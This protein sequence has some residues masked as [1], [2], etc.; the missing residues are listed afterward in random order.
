MSPSP[1]QNGQIIHSS[2]AHLGLASDMP[3]YSSSSHSGYSTNQQV[4]TMDSQSSSSSAAPVQ[5]HHHHHHLHAPLSARLGSDSHNMN[6]NQNHAHSNHGH[7]HS[8]RES[9]HPTENRIMVAVRSRPLT[10]KERML[11]TSQRARY[12]MPVIL[13]IQD[14][15][16]FLLDPDS[17]VAFDGAERA[18]KERVYTFDKVFDEYSSNDDVY[19]QT[20]KPLIDGVL[21]GYNATCFAYGMTGAGKTY[22]MMGRMD[23]SVKG[24]YALCMDDIFQRIRTDTDREYRVRVSFLEI[25][26]EKI[27][28]LLNP[29]GP[30]YLDLHE[31]PSKGMVVQ[32]LSEFEV[33]NVEDVQLIIEEGSKKRTMAATGANV[34]SSRSH[35]I[36]QMTVEQKDRSRN[37]VEELRVSKLN[38]IDLAGSERAARSDNRGIRMV[39]GANINRSLLA[40]GNCINILDNGGT[41]VP[42][43]DSKLTRLL[44]DSLGGNT[45]TVMIANVSPSVLYYEETHNTL[46]YASRAKNIRHKIT[47]NTVS[48]EQHISEYK[49]I[50]ESLRTEVDTLKTKIRMQTD[51]HSP[52]STPRLTSPQMSG[53]LNASNISHGSG[54]DAS[55]IMLSPDQQKL[56]E[57]ELH[58]LKMERI[59]MHSRI[60]EMQKRAL[61]AEHE[62]KTLE[63]E[64]VALRSELSHYKS[65]SSASSSP[66]LPSEDSTPSRDTSASRMVSPRLQSARRERK[67]KESAAAATTAVSVLNQ[68]QILFVKRPLGNTQQQQPHSQAPQQAPM[69]LQQQHQQVIR[70]LSSEFEQ[71]HET[72]VRPQQTAPKVPSRPPP[73]VQSATQRPVTAS[74]TSSTSAGAVPVVP[75]LNLASLAPVPGTA[76]P[77][78]GASTVPSASTLTSI[79]AAGTASS[80]A[81]GSVGPLSASPA[82][83]DQKPSAPRP[84]SARMPSSKDLGTYG[85]QSTHSSYTS[86]ASRGTLSSRVAGPGLVTPLSNPTPASIVSPRA[87]AG[88]AAPTIASQMSAR[89]PGPPT[90][91]HLSTR[92]RASAPSG[93]AANS[94][95]SNPSSAAYASS[96]AS[97]QDNV[98]ISQQPA[99]T[100]HSH[101]NGAADA[102]TSISIV[103]SS[104]N[105]YSFSSAPTPVSAA[106]STTPAVTLSAASGNDGGFE[107]EA[108]RI[109]KQIMERQKLLQKISGRSVSSSAT[110]NSVP[111][112]TILQPSTSANPSSASTTSAPPV[113]ALP[114]S[115]RVK[116]T[117]S[118]SLSADRPLSERHATGASVGANNTGLSQ[119]QN[120]TSGTTASA[121]SDKRRE[122]LAEK[123]KQRLA[124]FEDLQRQ[125]SAVLSRTSTVRA[126]IDGQSAPSTAR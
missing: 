113:P 79:S 17:G 70:R 34:A 38:L 55:G 125:V 12:K 71:E 75:K 82:Y 32:D 54:N 22:T 41:Y 88:Y 80:S 85:T 31:D 77:S 29:A 67:E 42:Y 100:Q 104:A 69:S 83:A 81:G 19:S 92:S 89:Y 114:L 44:K 23:G 117:G 63:K 60:L 53:A 66:R 65:N 91:A 51:G 101:S 110:N 46:K 18:R 121:P 98:P 36:F 93:P 20:T 123:Q 16:V 64:L 111:V 115:A 37:I 15:M 6:H 52:M 48:V 103:Q 109:R 76:T 10:E 86:L 27:K 68:D 62:Q 13:R 108:S 11:A 56:L 24:M 40:L 58:R 50:I 107:A 43:R 57:S 118:L 30:K 47:R 78:T 74:Q 35:A 126:Q 99:P 119:P 45:R 8:H 122:A 124:A 61:M 95:T 87:T 72:A 96:Y 39:E 33:K 73:S 97:N 1:P 14:A 90:E 112:S 102:A 3:L 4:S 21:D 9:A 2:S 94:A 28:D 5:H 49:R 84:L 26:N 106:N 105:S 59:D 7:S 116:S 120:G 25:Y